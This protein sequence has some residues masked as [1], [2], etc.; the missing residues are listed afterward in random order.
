M[1]GNYSWAR[2]GAIVQNN[3]AYRAEIRRTIPHREDMHADADSWGSRLKR[4]LWGDVWE[5]EDRRIVSLHWLEPIGGSAN[6]I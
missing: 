4:H 1:S 5:C 6:G 2:P 3:A